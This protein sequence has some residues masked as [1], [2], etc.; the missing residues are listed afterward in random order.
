MHLAYL[1]A[2]APSHKH[3]DSSRSIQQIKLQL[4]LLRAADKGLSF[5]GA[6]LQ[7][8]TWQRGSHRLW[9]RQAQ[10]QPQRQPQQKQERL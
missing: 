7:A 6:R 10:S 5:A 9:G 3:H 2:L 8:L 1:M 4:T